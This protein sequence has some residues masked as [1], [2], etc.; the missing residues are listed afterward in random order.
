MATHLSA[1]LP[2]PPGAW[3]AARKLAKNIKAPVEKFLAIEASSGIILLFAAFI[4][5]VWANSPWAHL[6]QA[7]WHTKLSFSLGSLSFSRDLHFWINDGL[8]AIFFFVVGLEIRREIA[9]GELSEMRR[10]AL[11]LVAALGGMLLP[12]IIY[13]AL[14]AGQESL[15]GWAIPMATDIAFAVGVLALLGKRVTPALR[16]LLLALAVI[17]DMGAIVIIAIF[18]STDL[19]WVG[20]AVAGGGVAT[21]LV[22]QAFGA[23]SLIFYFAPSL[24]VWGGIYA[25]GVH[26]TLAGVIVGLLTPAVAW[27]GPERFAERAESAAQHA[28]ND[29]PHHLL[30]QLDDVKEACKEAV[31]PVDRLQHELHGAVAFGIMPLFALANA[32]VSLGDVSFEGELLMTFL[33]IFFGLFVGKS[34]G[35][36]GLSWAAAKLNLA[37]LP[38]GVAWPHISVVGLVGGIGFTMALFIASLA[39]P[40]GPKLDISKLAILSGSATAA[41]VA[42][43]VG[44]SVLQTSSAAAL[45]EA[46]AE[47]S[48]ER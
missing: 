47:S 19:N 11:P 2:E 39:F 16:I 21:I 48:T 38:G 17:D 14:N 20:F 36:F 42:L 31:S 3:S 6:Y 12:A 26:P 7:L 25:G 27:Y 30:A 45:T 10:A 23:R 4:A 22:L 43:L 15:R 40:V 41:I 33:G 1:R 29:A 46:E 34:I 9:R 13:S 37:S 32:G 44:R 35:I 18:Y 8:M 24:V 5:L 28:K